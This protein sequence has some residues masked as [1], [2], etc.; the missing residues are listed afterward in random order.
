MISEIAILTSAKGKL[1][2]MA[3]AGSKGAKCAI[4]LTNRPESFL[5]T[6]QVGITL[7]SI[8]IGF[9]GGTSIAD[10]IAAKFSPLDEYWG[11]YS[12][13][14]GSVCSFIV[15]T[16]FTVLGEIVPKRIALAQPER[17][18][19]IAAYGMVV[20]L[21]AIYPL[22][23]LLSV[24]TKFLIRLLGVDTVTTYVSIEEIKFLVTQAENVGT[25]ARVE[26]NMINRL[27]H[28]N[29]MQVGAIMT[30]RNRII[31]LDITD[32]DTVNEAKVKEHTFSYFPVISGSLSTILG[33]IPIKTLFKGNGI[34]ANPPV[35]NILL[36]EF[37]KA[38]NVVYIPEV[39]RVTKLI[40]VFR[41]KH[42]KIAMVLDEYGEIEGIVTFSDVLKTF[43]GDITAL[44]E[45]KTPTIV[46][47]QDGSFIADGN[48]LIEEV[49]ESLNL[50]SVPGE[51]EEDYRTLASFILKQLGSIPQI[52]DSFTTTR[53]KFQVTKMDRFRIDRVL[54]IPIGQAEETAA[55]RDDEQ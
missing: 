22:V 7:M 17:F 8:L 40:E 5:S 33:V 15:I 49:K 16:Y 9:Y 12:S 30:P 31:A 51:E 24:S 54:I 28:L 38:S 18:A 35:N 46:A 27:V 25:L 34:A 21:N 29:N 39:A 2:K 26:R 19:A 32:N 3:Q 45:G 52:G 53:W 43:V 23:W 55:E 44:I 13:V 42:S 4:K 20:F 6:A 36:Y 48:A 50:L 14:L 10:Y 1:Y 41:Q 47:K 37:A 11:P